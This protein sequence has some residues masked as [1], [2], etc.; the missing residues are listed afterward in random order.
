MRKFNAAEIRVSI[1][2]LIQEPMLFEEV[3]ISSLLMKWMNGMSNM[4][5]AFGM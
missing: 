2:R 1:D 3:N 4:L 5:E